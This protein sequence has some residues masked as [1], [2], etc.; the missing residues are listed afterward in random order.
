MRP[1]NVLILTAIAYICLVWFSWRIIDKTGL[2]KA[3]IL[4][5]VIPQLAIVGLG[6]LAFTNWPSRPSEKVKVYTRK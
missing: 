3:L 2:H 5:F 1:L 6:V 4:L